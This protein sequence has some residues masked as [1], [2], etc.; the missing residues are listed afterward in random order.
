MEFKRASGILLHP[1]SLPGPHGIGDL[2]DAAY[3]F[4]DFLFHSKQKLWQILPL[5]P[6]GYGDA[7]YQCVSAF[8]GNPLLIS[9]ER[10]VEQGLLSGEDIIPPEDFP[11]D[12]VN[13]GAVIPYKTE[14]LQK[15]YQQFQTAPTRAN[16]LLHRLF[17]EFCQ[18]QADWLE[19]YALFM[20]LKAEQGGGSWVNWPPELRQREPEALAYARQ[21]LASAI[22]YYSFVQWLFFEQWWDL[23][24]AANKRGI[25]I[26]GD[27]PI[28][29]AYD[30]ADVWA[31]QALFHL[32]DNGQQTVVAG[33]PPDYFSATG[34]RWGNPLY[35]WEVMALD[36]YQW[37]IR[38]IHATLNQVDIIRIDHFRGFE[39]YWEIPAWEATAINGMWVKGP[40]A[41]FFEAVQK[42]L[43]GKLPFIAEDLGVITKEVNDLRS[44][45]NLPG[46]RIL[47]FAFGSDSSANYFLPHSYDRNT[48]VYTG[49]HDNE[50]IVGWFNRQDSSGTTDDVETVLRERQKAKRYA[51][52]REEDRIHWDFIRL[53][54][55]SVADFAIVPIQD[56]LGLGNEAR[57]N[58]PAGGSNNWQWRLGTELLNEELGNRLADLTELSGR[59]D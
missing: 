26:V 37:W 58:N 16:P 33:V 39:A 17:D 4:L 15:A 43:E 50:T 1:T 5:G 59:S 41:T 6:T 36:G 34:Q 8:G 55:M 13:F 40:G 7:P 52:L 14:R 2:G 19:D 44:Q 31:N 3:T 45:F 35:R 46:M 22:A 30:S 29:V 56:I 10:L 53:A 12:S 21:R 28:F 20:A 11:T 51:D 47:Q 42:G 32:D 38:R 24:H 27:I 25:Q 18:S 23:R 49:T 57:M 9:L 54:W 48:V